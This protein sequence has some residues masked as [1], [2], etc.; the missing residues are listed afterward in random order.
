MSKL[1]INS[2]VTEQPEP[3]NSVAAGH[4]G[5]PPLDE[6]VPEWGAGGIGNYFYWKAAHRRAWHNPSPGI[7]SFRI[8]N[9]ERLGLTYEE[10]TLEILERGRHLQVEDVERIA[11]IKQARAAR[12]ADRRD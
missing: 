8:R 2:F 11:E 9:A 7:V 6:H 12:A 10:Y 4:N 3:A 5:G 1:D